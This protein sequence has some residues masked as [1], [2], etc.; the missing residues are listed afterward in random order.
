MRLCL[1][2]TRALTCLPTE[3][4]FP[5]MGTATTSTGDR[6]TLWRA[7]RVATG[8]DPTPR[9]TRRVVRH[10]H[11]IARATLR[12]QQRTGSLR[13][14]VLGE[15][16]GDLAM[17]AIAEL[18]ERDDQ[19]RFSELRAY[20][21]G[22]LAAGRSEQEVE[23]KLRRLVQSA[24]TDWLFEAYRAADRSLSNQIRAL[25]R[26]V[27]RREDARL[28]RRGTVQWVELATGETSTGETSTGETADENASRAEDL[29]KDPSRLG[30][31]RPGRPMPLQVLEAHLTGAVA[32]AGSTGDLLEKALSALREHPVYEAAYPLTRLAQAMRSARVRVQAVTEHSGT[33]V[34]P[35]EPLLR[36]GETQR[37]IDETLRALQAEKRETYVGQS[38]LTEETYVA[39]FRALRDRLEARFVPPGDPEMTHYEALSGHLPL[40]KDEYREE[41]RSMFEYLERQAREKLVGRLE[42]VL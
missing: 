22:Q 40:G 10:C 12:Q 28:Q 34:S 17:D 36:P 37:Y 25:K 16:A 31:R 32:E 11:Q 6:L 35:E 7:L 19:G 42:E 23:E 4:G 38:K 14:D 3:N 29:P 13:E 9:A 20:F 39:Y 33:S 27:G 1:P 5:I 30:R 24:V 21:G 18:F 26:A 2:G 15:D 41:H 8:P